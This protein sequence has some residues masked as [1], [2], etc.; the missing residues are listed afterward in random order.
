MRVK[1]ATVPTF[2]TAAKTIVE[3]WKDMGGPNPI[4]LEGFDG[5]GK[6]GL[7]ELISKIMG[8][9][10]VEGDKFVDKYD[11]PPPYRDC[12]RQLEFDAAVQRAF[13]SGRVAILDAVC[14][15]EVASSA[16]WG[17]GFVV[18]VKRLSFNN[19]D[20]SWHN[21]IS[22]EDTPPGREVHR[23]IHSYHT[24]FK[25]HMSCDLI[26]ELPNTGHAMTKGDFSRDWCFDPPDA[27]LLRRQ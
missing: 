27:I 22:L 26:V 24:R 16:K 18:Y 11:E 15:E 23:S 9:E 8:G 21:G 19:R 12:I 5:V 17:R 25:P 2:D 1:I 10:H 3:C 13:N 14:L 6:S 4:R 7:A 20:P